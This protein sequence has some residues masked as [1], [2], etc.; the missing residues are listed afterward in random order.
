MIRVEI[1]RDLRSDVERIS[2]ELVEA[3]TRIRH[4]ASSLK[5]KM[6]QDV[7]DLVLVLDEQDRVNQE[8]SKAIKKQQRQI[9]VSE[10]HAR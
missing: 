10:T 9:E 6:Q 8:L 5:S 4:D 3:E 1:S 7:T 2:H